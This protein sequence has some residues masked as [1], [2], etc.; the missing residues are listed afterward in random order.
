MRTLVLMVVVLIVKRSIV[1][2]KFELTDSNANADEQKEK[3]L[4]N[5]P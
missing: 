5:Q 1:A 4:Q 3:E 2:V